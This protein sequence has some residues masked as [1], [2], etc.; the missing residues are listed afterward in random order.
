MPE[1]LKWDDV[2][3]LARRTSEGQPFTLTDETRAI[4]RRTA[5]QVAIPPDEAER[6]LQQEQSAAALLDEVASRIRVGSRRLSRAIVDS[7]N[8]QDAGDTDGAS[9]P[10]LDVL[11]VEVVPHY[12]A[13][14]QTHLD[15]LDD[16]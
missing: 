13:I 3:N 1:D 16:S 10:F 2:R 5:P 9:Q 11:A 4:L 15:A 8:R 7:A 6:A 12:R 14:A